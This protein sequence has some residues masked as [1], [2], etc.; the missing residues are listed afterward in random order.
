MTCVVSKAE[1]SKKVFNV[2]DF[3]CFGLSWYLLINGLL[4][5]SQI[6]SQRYLFSIIKMAMPNRS[7]EI[8][9][10]CLLKFIIK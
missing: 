2:I 3:T 7:V 8:I 5:M 4:I 10:F 9:K 6:H 1:Y